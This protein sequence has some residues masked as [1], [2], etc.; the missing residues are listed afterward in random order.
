[1]KGVKPPVERGREY[2]IEITGLGHSGE[3][4]GK[5]EGFTVFVQQALP[6]E[7]VV[8]RIVE[9]K[10]NYATGRLRRVVRPSEKRRTP[11]CP[12]Y[13]G[14]GGCQLQ[15][16]SYAG[17]LE[18]KGETVKAAVM[19][20]GKLGD[21]ELLSV[22]GAENE[23]NYR[24]KMQFP[25][26]CEG[27]RTVSGCFAAGSHKV[28]PIDDCM[29]QHEL[30]DRIAQAVKTYADRFNVP[31]YDEATGRGCLRHV[32]GR[33]GAA[34]G[35]AMAVIVTAQAQLPHEAE[36][37]ALLREAAPELVSI[38]QN[39]NP[40]RTNVVLGA[41]NR[42]L[43]GSETI[44]EQLGHL[45]FKISP[46]SFFQVNTEQTL[47]LY[48][49][50]LEFAELGGN[51]TVVDAYCGTGTISLFLAQRAA[52]VYGFEIVEA[53]I[54]DAEKNAAANGITNVE[55]SVG[56]V[57][58]TLP[59]LLAKG[60]RPDVIVVD[61]PRAGCEQ[62]VLETFAA[63]QPKRMVYVSCNPASLARDLAVLQE[64]GYKTVKIQPVD[65]FPQTYHVECVALI[66]R[67]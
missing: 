46:H 24:N 63:M 13:Y 9:V 14:C 59:E 25:L 10:K 42:V 57:V 35:Q 6:Q 55:F 30:N 12:V 7:E 8:V 2:N 15:H 43:W 28:I 36:L 41:K 34:T 39:I 26:G 66:E 44:E 45:K 48:E 11:P 23:W 20:I 4:V 18:A 54:R 58:E 47:R 53:A 60:V 1:M 19:R 38:V 21:I 40:R 27:G 16:L 62:K 49:K 22:L 37:T 29:I 51:E 52:K 3:G 31:V 61:P 17:Q 5:Y 50:A 67:R 33:V 56:D 65:M 64:N 32:M